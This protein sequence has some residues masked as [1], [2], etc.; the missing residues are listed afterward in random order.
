L[1]PATT[2]HWHVERS[3]DAAVLVLG[4]PTPGQASTS[5]A[6][7][8]V[9]AVLRELRGS[10]R[11]RVVST[12]IVRWDTPLILFLWLLEKAL[13]FEKLKPE[14]DLSALPEAPRRLLALARVEDDAPVESD[15]PRKAGLAGRVGLWALGQWDAAADLSA[16]LGATVLVP[17]T[18]RAVRGAT[19]A[20]DV[21]EQL[22]HAG[23]G[24]LPIVAVV[25]ILVG[26]ILAFIGAVQLARFG[27][28]DYIADLVGIAVTRE[29]APMMTAIVIAGRTGGAY[30]AEIAMMQGSEEIDALLVTGIPPFSYL[31]LPRVIA[32]L[33][34]LP[35]LY[36]YACLVGIAGGAVVGVTMLSMSPVAFFVHLRS[37]LPLTEF[38]IGFTKCACFGGFI[39]L[40]SCRIGL[41]AGRSSADVGAAATGAVVSGIVG[42]IALDAIFAACANALRI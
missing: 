4:A 24:A 31:V 39:A 11:L 32:L 41:R 26:A 34:M 23:S 29:M 15:A 5:L 36:F 18:R 17:W 1:S 13:H 28:G 33:T 8:A 2:P 30:A 25:N 6:V 42:V 40:S 10:T 27:A 21:V 37:A 12:D 20:R 35:V 9:P 14:L 19:R 38:I 22:N 7:T 3:P 16:L